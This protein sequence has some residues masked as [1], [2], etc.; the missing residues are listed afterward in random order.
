MGSQRALE[1]KRGVHADE[2]AAG[3]Q[4]AWRFRSHR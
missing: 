3:D 4:N 1:S 2:A